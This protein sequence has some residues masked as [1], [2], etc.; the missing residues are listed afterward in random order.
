MHTH[1]IKAEE[2][3]RGYILKSIKTYAIVNSVEH[4]GLFITVSIND[5]HAQ[6]IYKKGDE[7]EVALLAIDF[8]KTKYTEVRPV[9]VTDRKTG[10]V[11]TFIEYFESKRTDLEIGA[12]HAP[13]DNFTC[14]SVY[15]VDKKGFSSIIFDF[16]CKTDAEVFEKIVLENI[17]LNNAFINGF[18]SWQETHFEVVSKITQEAIKKE[19][20]GK[21]AE[22]QEANGIG[23]LYE[24][25]EELT[26]KFEKMYA[27][28]EWGGEFFDEIDAF[29]V[30][31]LYTLETFEI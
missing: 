15:A 18:E 5:G 24:L 10:K 8:A 3:K 2:I 31:E 26:N 20:A 29:L 28:F 19:P 4:N 30:C 22:V 12:L 14:W 1:V 13:N 16:M 17:A 7:V 21:V 6:K 25:A 9:I 11:L 27:G 23:A